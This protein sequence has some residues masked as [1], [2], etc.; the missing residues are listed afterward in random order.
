[1]IL[2]YKMKFLYFLNS[3][4]RT[5]GF[6][7]IR[8][9]KWFKILSNRYILILLL[10][11]IW[12]LFFDSNSWLVHHDLNQTIEEL[13]NNKKYYKAQIKKD[14]AII[15]SLNDPDEL[16]K[17]A[18]EKYFMKRKNEVIYIIEYADSIKTKENE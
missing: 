5:M 3:Y 7:Q 2:K 13:Q 14:T 10:F 12:M 16:E 11:S 6:K 17:F 9:K 15:N 18:R 4:I 1:M 8:E